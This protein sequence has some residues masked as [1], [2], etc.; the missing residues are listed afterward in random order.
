MKSP[1]IGKMG[2]SF[3]ENPATL[4]AGT[5]IG[6]Y[7]VIKPLGAGGMGE[8]YLARDT[9][10]NRRVALKFLPSQFTS[11]S[12]R[13]ARFNREAEAASALNHPNILTVYE[14]NSFD[15]VRFIAA[16]LLTAKRCA[17]VYGAAI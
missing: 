11:S 16:N 2:E 10:L 12:E 14:I 5:R 7:R 6:R 3:N 1:L 9:T 17:S 13:L 15:D 4:D 8:V